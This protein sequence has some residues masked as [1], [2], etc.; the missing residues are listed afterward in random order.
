MIIEGPANHTVPIGATVTFHCIAQGEEAFFEINDTAIYYPED[1]NRFN[2][3]GF[4]LHEE[5]T[6]TIFNF[7]MKVNAMP[8]NNN[9]RITCWVYPPDYLSGNLT[10]MGKIIITHHSLIIVYEAQFTALRVFDIDP[11][12]RSKPSYHV[13][14]L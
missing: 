2:E 9:T 5:Y 3:R 8:E 12:Y 11:K 13:L 1:M 10:V 4:A 14:I 6:D 7:T